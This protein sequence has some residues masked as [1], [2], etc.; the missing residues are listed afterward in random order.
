MRLPDWQDR[1][2]DVLARQG[3]G[4]AY[5]VNDCCLF[6]ADCAQAITGTDYA[7]EFRGYDV[8]GAARILRRHGGLAGLMDYLLGERLPANA[9]REGDVLLV[10]IGRRDL[11]GVRAGYRVAV[12][13]GLT[14]PLSHAL[15]SWR[16]G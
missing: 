9:A 3:Q 5:G 15:H 7:A 12:V 1:L 11:V 8:R 6:A 2:R 4:F 14:A 16:V 10:R 13:R